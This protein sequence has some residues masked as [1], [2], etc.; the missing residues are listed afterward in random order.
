M[1]ILPKCKNIMSLECLIFVGNRGAEDRKRI[2]VS[3]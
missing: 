3:Y 1:E 2:L